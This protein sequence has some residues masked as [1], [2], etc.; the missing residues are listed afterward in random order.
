MI[1]SAPPWLVLGAAWLALFLYAFPGQMTKDSFDHLGEVRSGMYT[2]S[3]PPAITWLWRVC[4]LFVVG[5]AGMLVVQLTT[6]LLGLYG[7]MRVTFTPRAAAWVTAML[8]VWP[9]VMLPFAVIW[10][11]GVMAGCLM[12]GAAGLCSGRRRMRLLALV[13]LW[14]ASAVRY[15]A[16][17]ATL[18]LVVLLFEWREG[19]P[20]IKRYAL[21][22]TAWLAVTLAAFGFNAALADKKMHFWHSSLAVFDIVG[23][24]DHVDDMPD[25]EL[26]RLFEGTELKPQRDIHQAIRSIY[27]PRD[28]MPIIDG[29][30]LWGLPIQGTVP[31]PAAQRDAIGRAWWEVVSGHP[32]AYLEHRLTVFGEVIGLGE[33]SL[34]VIPRDMR[35][36]ELAQQFGLQT[37]WTKLQY[38][39]SD[40]LRWLDR[41]TSLF[42]P[43]IYLVLS[44]VLLPLARRHRDVLALLLSGLVLVSSLVFLAPS[45][46]Y[47]YSHWMVVCTLVAVVVVTARRI[48]NV[49][50]ARP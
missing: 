44:L 42:V 32:L 3:H 18:P 29:N 15:N 6:F 22:C 14:F 17:G 40:G 38:K 27:N 47:R 9:P 36:P 33:K 5:P 11:D 49:R 41:H 50:E 23:T 48:A 25:D 37:R 13:P 26:V 46:D 34:A 16:F 19:L 28:F 4:E 30:G 31:A 7:V 43:W 39:L 24:L 12:L 8:Y 10:K 45:V 20:W 2:D 21:A 35:W 1:A